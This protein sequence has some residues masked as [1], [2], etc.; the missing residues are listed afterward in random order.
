MAKQIFI[1]TSIELYV[2]ALSHPY[3][4][5]IFSRAIPVV[6]SKLSYFRVVVL[7]FIIPVVV[8]TNTLGIEIIFHKNI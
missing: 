7:Y 2:L 4:S 5:V 1:K 8:W 3:F 6:K